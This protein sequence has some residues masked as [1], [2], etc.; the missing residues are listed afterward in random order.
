MDM[1]T[2]TQDVC[3]AAVSG[4]PSGPVDYTGCPARC[5]LEL[6]GEVLWVESRKSLTGNNERSLSSKRPAG[7]RA[8][9]KGEYRGGI[10]HG[11]LSAVFCRHLEK[12]ASFVP[13]L[14]TARRPPLPSE[15]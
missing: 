8:R 6:T 11:N 9:V 10:R 13:L 4:G 7:D 1:D 12:R 2:P 15:L 3:C 5:S 14:T